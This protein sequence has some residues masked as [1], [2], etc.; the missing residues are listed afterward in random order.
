MA[1][2]TAEFREFAVQCMRWSEETR[3]AGQRDLM[4]RV[5]TTWM[6]TASSLD[7]RIR[8]GDILVPDLRCK[9]D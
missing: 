2:S 5:A 6:R 9:L 7:R 4:V 1:V 8:E 3:D